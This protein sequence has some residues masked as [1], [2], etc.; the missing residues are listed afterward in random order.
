MKEGKGECLDTWY[1]AALLLW[2]DLWTAALHN[3]GSGSQRLR[4]TAVPP[5]RILSDGVTDRRLQSPQHH[6]PPTQRHRRS[7]AWRVDE[8][9]RCRK[10]DRQPQQ[11]VRSAIGRQDTHVDTRLKQPFN[12]P[13]LTD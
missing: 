5:T 10:S 12:P 9:P 1:S 11:I 7:V 4:G 13:N 3:L 8:Q 6:G 2:E